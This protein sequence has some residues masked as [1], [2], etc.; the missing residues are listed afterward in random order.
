MQRDESEDHDVQEGK[1]CRNGP[2]SEHRPSCASASTCAG[3]KRSPDQKQK[4]CSG[5]RYESVTDV[6]P[7]RVVLIHVVSRPPDKLGIIR[8]KCAFRQTAV[9]QLR[10]NVPFVAFVGVKF[11]TIGVGDSGVEIDVCDREQI[12]TNKTGTRIGHSKVIIGA[13]AAKSRKNRSYA[14]FLKQCAGDIR[15]HAPFDEEDLVAGEGAQGAL[16]VIRFADG[17]GRTCEATTLTKPAVLQ[18]A[19]A[20]E[21]CDALPAG[22]FGEDVA[23]IRYNAGACQLEKHHNKKTDSAYH[24]RAPP[25][26][27][28]RNIMS[29]FGGYVNGDFC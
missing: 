21:E 7:A 1:D 16:I 9:D 15:S 11:Q 27:A 28:E 14:T 20:V 24:A 26:I 22:S 29:C 13:R 23:V 2:V 18:R 5:L 25:M 6:I 17:T 8:R 4:A 19:I 10:V 3:Q 12:I